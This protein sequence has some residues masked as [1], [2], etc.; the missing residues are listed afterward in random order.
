MA[1]D[2]HRLVP[3]SE[4][5]VSE[6]ADDAL[7]PAADLGPEAGVQQGDAHGDILR[8][9]LVRRAVNRLRRER[10]HLAAAR[11]IRVWLLY[12]PGPGPWPF[13]WSTHRANLSAVTGH[14]GQFRSPNREVRSSL[15]RAFRS[16]SLGPASPGGQ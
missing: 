8:A 4:Q 12:L 13:T 1:R 2:Q 15:I 11:S 5:A 3:A 6:L 10:G 16:S 14:W 7:G 9:M